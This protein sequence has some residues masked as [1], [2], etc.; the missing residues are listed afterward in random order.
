MAELRAGQEKAAERRLMAM[1][2]AAA[3]AD[4][5]APVY[6]EAGVPFAEGLLAFHRGRYAAA[7]EHMLPA[8]FAM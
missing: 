7:L 2:D 3:G 1:R 4:E 8:R 6:R 5:G